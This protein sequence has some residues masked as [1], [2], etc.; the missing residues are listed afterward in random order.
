MQAIQINKCVEIFGIG[1]KARKG[2]L[3]EKD[4]RKKQY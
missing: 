4:G 2:K 3:W 1:S